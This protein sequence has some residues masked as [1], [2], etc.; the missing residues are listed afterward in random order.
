MNNLDATVTKVEEPTW[1][2]QYQ[3]YRVKIEYNCWGSTSTTEKWY[4][5]R[6]QAYA[7]KVGDTI[8]V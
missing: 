7:L 6:E 4:K 3:T 8:I 2:A 5:D 1:D